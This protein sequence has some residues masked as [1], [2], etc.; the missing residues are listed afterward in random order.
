M[1]M[2]CL[3]REL[4]QKILIGDSIDLT[5]LDFSNE[6]GRALIGLDVP[7]GQEI[8][9]DVPNGREVRLFASSRGRSVFG[10]G[11]PIGQEVVLCPSVRFVPLSIGR[12]GLCVGVDAPRNIPVDRDEVRNG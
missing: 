1:G 12:D 9:F 10:F 5:V 2:L 3:H 11:I 4:G 7:A 6:S 8:C